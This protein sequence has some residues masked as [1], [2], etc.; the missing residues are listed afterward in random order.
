MRIYVTLSTHHAMN[1]YVLS[2]FFTLVHLHRKPITYFLSDACCRQC[3]GTSET[4]VKDVSNMM[5]TINASGK[6]QQKVSTHVHPAAIIQ[7]QACPMPTGEHTTVTDDVTMRVHVHN[8]A[9]KR[10]NIIKART[11][12]VYGF[13]SLFFVFPEI[14]FSRARERLYIFIFEKKMK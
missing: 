14:R 9:K 4:S 2:L 3:K 6:G 1:H 7:T 5:T 10:E 12:P 8:C 13:Y 11:N